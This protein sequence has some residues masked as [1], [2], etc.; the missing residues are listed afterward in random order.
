V[1]PIKDSFLVRAEGFVI[2]IP[3]D[4][5]NVNM[6]KLIQRDQAEEILESFKLPGVDW[7]ENNHSRIQAY[8]EI[9]RTGNRKDIAK[10]ANTLIR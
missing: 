2:S 8:Y 6:S 1:T 3:V 4:N 10:V 9:V 5:E 7:I